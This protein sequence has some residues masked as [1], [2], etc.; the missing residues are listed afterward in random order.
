MSGNSRTGEVSNLVQF[1]EG[2]QYGFRVDEFIPQSGIYLAVHGDHRLSHEVTLLA[3]GRFPRCKKC[4]ERVTFALI[5][6]APAGIA[7]RDFR[8]QLYE[9]P[10]P[11][12]EADAVPMG[13]TA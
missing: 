7:D 8:I 6:A 9:I 1:P 5:K 12:D 2:T 13:N 3:G 11:Y 4:G 10:H